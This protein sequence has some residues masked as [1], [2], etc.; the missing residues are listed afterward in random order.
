M[1]EFEREILS[2]HTPCRGLQAEDLAQAL[3][4]VHAELVLIHP[5]REGNGRSAMLLATLMA[6][7]AGIPV[8]DFRPLDGKG[9]TCYFAAIQAALGRNYEP[10]TSRFAL[11]LGRAANRQRSAH[12]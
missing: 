4:I 10:I 9:K 12:D 8:L 2:A 3:G 1:D 5:F 7:Q 6:L 11:V